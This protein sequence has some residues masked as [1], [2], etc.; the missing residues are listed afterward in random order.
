[1]HVATRKSYDNETSDV[2]RLNCS[3]VHS[4][5]ADCLMIAA[6][7]TVCATSE[8]MPTKGSVGVLVPDRNAFG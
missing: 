5:I 3:A 1:M 6:K 2:S 7:S 4:H 8:C